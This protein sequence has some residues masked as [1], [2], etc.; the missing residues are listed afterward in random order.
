MKNIVNIYS[1]P[2]RKMKHIRFFFIFILLSLSPIEVFSLPVASV[3]D[4]KG[5]VYFKDDPLKIGEV[6]QGE[7]KLQTYKNSFI[8]LY[9][10]KWDTTLILG[11]QSIIDLK[12]TNEEK[13][14][15]NG[16]Y[17]YFKKGVCRWNGREKVDSR[18]DLGAIHTKV[19][20]VGSQGAEFLLKHS[21]LLEESE[22]IVFEGKVVFKNK[23]IDN[24]EIELKKSHWLGIGGRFGETL[25]KP[26]LIKEEI[27]KK[28]SK[29][30]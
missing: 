26:L 21:E 25:R 11:P 10:D 14:S 1:M 19:S 8:K 18:V 16:M 6:V 23:I 3:V 15:G 29:S 2:L 30:L 27:L 4:I 20:I 22:V 13:M 24:D 28:F 7:G 12:L 9:I 17:Y 5:R